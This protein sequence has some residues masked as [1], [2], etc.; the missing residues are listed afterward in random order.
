MTLTADETMTLSFDRQAAAVYLDAVFGRD[1][2]FAALTFG[3]GGYRPVDPRTGELGKYDHREWVDKLSYRWPAERERLLA[4][5]AQELAAGSVDVYVCPMLRAHDGG[6]STPG[7]GG[8]LAWGDMDGAVLPDAYRDGGAWIVDSGTPGHM[9]VYVPLPERRDATGVETISNGLTKILGGDSKWAHNSL[10]RLPGTWN[11]KHDPPT[12]VRW[13]AGPFPRP[14]APELL[15]TLDAVPHPRQAAESVSI[16]AESVKL[17]EDLPGSVRTAL[18]RNNGIGSRSTDVHNLV[19]VCVRAGLSDGEV[20]AVARTY[21]PA[22]SKWG[23]RGRL[24]GEVSR[25]LGKIRAESPWVKPAASFV[26]EDAAQGG[27]GRPSLRSRLLGRSAL[28][29]L[30]R[31][32]PLIE[33]TLDRRTVALLAGPS[34]VGKSFVSLGMGCAIAT[35]T[36][37]LGREAHRGRVLYIAAEGAFGLDVRIGAWEAATGVQVDDEWFTVL[38]EAVQLTDPS[39]PDVAELGALVADVGYR[40]VVVDTLARSMVG[41]DENSARD[42]GVAVDIADRIRR[43]AED[44]TVLLVHH[45]GKDRT[46]VRG[47]SALEAAVDTVYTLDGDADLIKMSRTKRKEGPREDTLTLRLA[48]SAESVT[49]ESHFAVGTDRELV[50]S[51]TQL[52]K[53]MWDSFGTTGATG[54][55]LR[56]TC[57]LSKSTYYRAL[58]SLLSKGALTNQGSDA[59]PLYKAVRRAD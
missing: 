29:R 25:C 49:V 7:A 3:R 23:D 5:V 17:P 41:A 30:P 10:L 55:Q 48:R 47:S 50:K 36:Q 26:P 34:N 27:A 45:T 21:G 46:T 8:R 58:N 52:L 28:G 56:D 44:S 39:A 40:L 43:A 19:G 12:P 1:E 16:D 51:E 6:R 54:T 14:V 59:R 15:A 2:G 42:M 53:I 24:D 32:E 37:W 18:G 35:G 11:F 9:H 20:L 4:E 57:G 33:G 38:P 13:L 22:K 31:P